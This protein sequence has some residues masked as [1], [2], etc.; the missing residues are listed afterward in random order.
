M[1]NTI[2]TIIPVSIALEYLNDGSDVDIKEEP[3]ENAIEITP[4]FTLSEQNE[5]DGIPYYFI[6]SLAQFILELCF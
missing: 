4:D 3:G 5:A 2:D 6:E 1:S